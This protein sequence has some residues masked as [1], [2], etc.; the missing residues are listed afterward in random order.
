VLPIIEEL[1]SAGV[2]SLRGIAGALNARGVQ[3]ARGG[4]WDPTTVKRILAR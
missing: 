1:R 2:G 4:R 3:T